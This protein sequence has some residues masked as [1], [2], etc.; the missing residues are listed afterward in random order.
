MFL[1]E[2]HEYILRFS[3]GFSMI[4]CSESNPPKAIIL[5]YLDL[6]RK[7]IHQ[8]QFKILQFTTFIRV[9]QNRRSKQEQ[10]Q[11]CLSFALQGGGRRKSTD[12]TVRAE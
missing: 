5:I 11:A 10:N 4:S 8:K 6:L 3:L 1:D 9:P 2:V 12:G 7:E